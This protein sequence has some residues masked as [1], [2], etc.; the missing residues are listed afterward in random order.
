MSTLDNE[1]GLVSLEGSIVR[2]GRGRAEVGHDTIFENI[3]LTN[4]KPPALSTQV[5][6]VNYWGDG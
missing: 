6:K 5:V 3:K 2:E 1:K 4:R